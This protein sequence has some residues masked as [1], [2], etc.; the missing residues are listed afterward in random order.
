MR[1]D[2]DENDGEALAEA[3]RSLHTIKG[4][5]AALGLDVVSGLGHEAESRLELEQ[6]NQ[7]ARLLFETAETL[8][9][10]VK[11]LAETGQEIVPE[12]QP[13][14]LPEA[15]MVPSVPATSPPAAAPTSPPTGPI[16][17]DNTDRAS[18][19]G[20]V[21]V[22]LSRVDD[23]LNVV[24]E[25]V[26]TRSSLEQ[27]LERLSRSAEELRLTVARLRRVAQYL[28]DRY[29][30]AEL[31]RTTPD[32]PRYSEFDELEM[33]RYTELHRVSREVTE[34]AAD[35]ETTSDD[36]DLAIKELDTLAR[37]QARLGSDLQDRLMSVRLVPLS[38]LNTRLHR[39]VRS[40]ALK[41]GKEVEFA[42]EGGDTE[43]DKR[44]LEDSSAR[45]CCT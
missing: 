19:S 30:V 17:T 2:L 15:T 45:F 13:F 31:L 27:R 4:S 12:L 23:L 39:T 22:E 32:D 28:E 37:R 5:A 7:Y 24:G 35:A 14:S 8:E 9:L 42:I 43:L 40:T 36:I 11:K 6:P 34:L 10:V 21:R 20:T 33:D 44:V 18:A 3:R 29:E 38:S 26:L 1:L 16:A 41:Q 25:V